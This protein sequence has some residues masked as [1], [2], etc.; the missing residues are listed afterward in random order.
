MSCAIWERAHSERSQIELRD[1]ETFL[2]LSVL[3]APLYLLGLY[4]GASVF[5]KKYTY[6]ILPCRGLGLMGLALDLVD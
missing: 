4:Y 6:F 1:R 2:K 3:Q 5:K